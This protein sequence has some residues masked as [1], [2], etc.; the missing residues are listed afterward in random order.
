LR[1]QTAA[2]KEE[3]ERLNTGEYQLTVIEREREI[4]EQD[5]LTH[6][7]RRTESNMSEELDQRRIVNVAVLSPPDR[8]IQ[9][10]YPRK[11]MM[12]GIS[13]PIGLLLGIAL[14]LFTGYL[15]DVI[16]TPRDL[17]GIG[18]FAYLG[19]FHLEE[20]LLSVESPF[21]GNSGPTTVSL[22]G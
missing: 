13:A 7:K 5:Y 1:I 4:A 19:T 17:A 21:Q 10:V 22:P 18:G 2:I 12:M 9:P 15:S 3:L 14:V 11:L 6:V 16:S 8:P 20:P